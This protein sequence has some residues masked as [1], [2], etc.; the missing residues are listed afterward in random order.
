MSYKTVYLFLC[1]HVVFVHGKQSLCPNI[2]KCGCRESYKKLSQVDCRGINNMTELKILSK[3]LEF[4]LIPVLKIRQCKAKSIPS[5]SFFNFSIKSFSSS[6]PF[7]NIDD[8]SLKQIDSL[9]ELK[10]FTTEFTEIPTAVGRLADLRVL[11]VND[12]KLTHVNMEVQNMTRLRELI[13]KNNKIVQISEKAFHGNSNLKIIDLS[14]NNLTSLSPEI[15]EES[16]NLKKVLLQRNRLNSTKGIFKN[17]NIQEINIRDNRLKSIDDAFKFELELEVLDLGKN[18][19]KQIGPKAFDWKVRQ[20]KT[21]IL[22]QCELFSLPSM[23]FQYLTKLEKLDLSHNKLETISPEIFQAL[24]N[25]REI[26]LSGNEIRILGDLFTKNSRLERIDL[27]ENFIKSCDSIFYGLQNLK[28]IDLSANQLEVIKKSD[29]LTTPS[30]TNLILSKNNISKIESGSFSYLEH[31]TNLSLSFN[32]L[33][34][35]N[36]SLKNAPEL[37]IL[38]LKNNQ[39]TEIGKNEFSNSPKLKRINL[40]YNSLT[41]IHGA[42]RNL[43]S[44]E[45]LTISQNRLTTLTRNTFSEP[46]KLKVIYASGLLP[47]VG[48]TD[49]PWKTKINK[50]SSP[51]RGWWRGSGSLAEAI[52]R[53]DE[54]G[55]KNGGKRKEGKSDDCVSNQRKGVVR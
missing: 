2:E 34:S 33:M 22:D 32:R 51:Q 31:L 29:F 9:R 45:T 36:N 16:R 24:R 12:G 53:A 23:V 37:E 27:S 11:F 20:L 25:L 43:I 5:N 30:I 19:L 28:S 8:D 39:F 3:D 50:S 42:F 18:P 15:F 21:L 26:N 49:R 10:L 54:P 4:M 14:E 55:R 6:C 44:L 17:S 38:L 52:R 35:L 46:F 47:K 48:E 1:F 40:G 13:L 41:D 7:S